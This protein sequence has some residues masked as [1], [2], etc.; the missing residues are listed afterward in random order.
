[1][2][3]ECADNTH[4]IDDKFS[5]AL[6]LPLAEVLK[7]VTVVLMKKLEAH[8]KV[9]VLQHGLVIIHQGQF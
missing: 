6:S 9:M 5:Q 4:H 2:Q 8:S 3:D 7:D 1:M